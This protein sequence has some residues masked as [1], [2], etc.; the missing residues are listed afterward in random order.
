MTRQAAQARKDLRI[1]QEARGEAERPQQAEIEAANR[2]AEEAD[3]RA[4]EAM[5]VPFMRR[6]GRP[7]AEAQKSHVTGQN[8]LTRSHETN[9][10]GSLPSRS[11]HDPDATAQARGMKPKPAATTAEA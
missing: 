5:V 7:R 4:D 1:M 9:S 11:K 3:R 6:L 8:P 10:R 2:S